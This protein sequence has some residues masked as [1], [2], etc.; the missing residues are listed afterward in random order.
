M[1]PPVS[2]ASLRD[3]TTVLLTVNIAILFHVS[4]ATLLTVS[5]L[6]YYQYR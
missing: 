1:F 5:L 2:I 3:V 4:V 6:S